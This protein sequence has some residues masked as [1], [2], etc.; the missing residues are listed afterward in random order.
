[1][2]NVKV[3]HGH[4][5]IRNDPRRP[6]TLDSPSPLPTPDGGRA[7]ALEHL[8]GSSSSKSDDELLN[9]L[10]VDALTI[11]N[12]SKCETGTLKMWAGYRIV[13]KALEKIREATNG[14]RYNLHKRFTLPIFSSGNTESAVRAA[15]SF[16]KEHGSTEVD[17]IDLV[18]VPPE[19]PIPSGPISAASLDA[20]S[21]YFCDMMIFHFREALLQNIP[22]PDVIVVPVGSGMLAAGVMNASR[23]LNKLKSM[24]PNHALLYLNSNLNP[25][26][27]HFFT[28][29]DPSDASS[30]T[31][32]PVLLAIEEGSWLTQNTPNTSASN[33]IQFSPTVQTPV[34]TRLSLTR[35]PAPTLGALNKFKTDHGN[36]RT[37][38]VPSEDIITATTTLNQNGIQAEES[39]ATAF[40]ALKQAVQENPDEFRGKNIWVVNSGQGEAGRQK[41]NPPHST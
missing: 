6:M 13:Q 10:G 5:R 3:W 4:A 35:I 34:A 22:L 7:I 1:M 15:L 19:D 31:N 12:G 17:W 28:G 21:A 8:I 23:F 11:V 20:N 18:V 41:W 38:C 39:A 40:A 32:P 25:K 27:L 37:V 30:K 33:I 24:D 2:Y 36:N 26:N 14:S 16:F 9:F 29:N